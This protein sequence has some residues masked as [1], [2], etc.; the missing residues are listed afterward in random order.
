MKKDERDMIAGLKDYWNSVY[1]SREITSL[2]WYG[3][4]PEVEGLKFLDRGK[5]ITR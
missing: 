2:G 4:F 1:A 3:P 5:L